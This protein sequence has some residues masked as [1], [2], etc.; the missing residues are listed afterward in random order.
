MVD[1]VFW[2]LILVSALIGSIRG[3]WVTTFGIAGLVTGYLGAYT[4]GP[5]L[6][7]ELSIA[8]G[9]PRLI[10]M[11]AG[12]IGV[13][14][15]GNVAWKIISW[16]HVHRRRKKELA[17]ESWERVAGFTLGGVQGGVMSVLLLWCLTFLPPGHQLRE[18][19]EL[20]TSPTIRFFAP[21]MRR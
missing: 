7:S 4:V 18:K 5:A 2:G 21:L 3:I 11:L 10:G 8:Y 13:F 1:L 16:V 15:A 14:V 6:G 9:W 19:L 12:G 20:N 17:M